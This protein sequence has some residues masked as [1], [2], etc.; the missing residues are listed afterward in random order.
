[1][2]SYDNGRMAWYA[3]INL[4]H[5]NTSAEFMCDI[6]RPVPEIVV[7]EATSLGFQWKFSSLVFTE[8]RNVDDVV[9]QRKS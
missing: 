6:S 7:C 8:K 4:L 1:M 5:V 2:C 3:F 9:I